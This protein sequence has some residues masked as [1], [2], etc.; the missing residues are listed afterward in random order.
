[1]KQVQARLSE[2]RKCIAYFDKGLKNKDIP[3]KTND[4]KKSISD[5][6]KN[7]DNIKKEDHRKRRRNSKMQMTSKMKKT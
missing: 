1:M 4:L 2:Q 6:L 5:H 7:Q 3:K